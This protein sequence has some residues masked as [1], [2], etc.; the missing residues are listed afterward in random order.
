MNIWKAEWKKLK[1]SKIFLPIFLLP[2][3][4]VVFGSLNYLGNVEILK[5]EWISL[6]TQVYLFYGMFFLPA[7]IGIICAYVWNGEHKNGNMKLLQGSTQPIG[8]IVMVK[9]LVALSLI[10][11]VQSLLFLFYTI[12]GFLIHFESGLPI[13]LFYYLVL[14]TLLSISLVGMQS[15]LSLK[16][17]SFAIPVA[18]ALVFSFMGTMT[19]GKVMDG[20]SLGILEYIFPLSS[21]TRAMNYYP[22][23][24]YGV[25]DFI[26]MFVMALIL[27]ALFYILQINSLKKQRK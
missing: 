27:L 9:M 4:S 20:W 12:S 17:K 23:E 10:F 13:K 7:L 16:I 25:G 18:V 6:W 11:L 5:K 2:L 22:E 15:Y 26:Q 14:A 8:K 3:F 1:G 21:I 19:M 24:I